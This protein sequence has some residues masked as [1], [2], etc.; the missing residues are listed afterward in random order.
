MRR[1]FSRIAVLSIALAAAVPTPAHAYQNGALPQSELSQIYYP[2]A[3]V[4]LQKDAAAAWNA[5]REYCRARGVDLYPK[6]P[7]SAY[8]TLAQQKLM[9]KLYG[10]NAATPGTSNHGLGI[11]VDLATQQMRSAIDKWGAQFGWSKKWSDASWEWWHIKYKAGVWHGA[12]PGVVQPDNPT[13]AGTDDDGLP[14]PSQPS[15]GTNAGT[16]NGGG[17]TT[18]PGAVPAGEP[19]AVG[20]EG[21]SANTGLANII[22]NAATRPQLERGASGQDVRDLQKLL[23]QQGHDIDADGVFGPETQRAV[24][25][26]QKKKK[27][28]ADGVVGPKTWAALANP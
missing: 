18:E 13:T 3:S 10:S 22:V 26:F 23:R 27:L 5:M 11:A 19:I 14:T 15:N 8:R 7:N 1:G 2:G 25:E 6:G 9:K 16:T 21:P 24:K 4:Y 12:N 17:T 20:G 28:G